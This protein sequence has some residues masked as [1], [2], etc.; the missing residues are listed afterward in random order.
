S[1]SIWRQKE[2]FNQELYDNIDN[3][4]EK[5]KGQ[6]KIK[7]RPGQDIMSYDI[8]DII[9]NKEIL[10]IEAGVG[11][12]KSWAY[13]ITLISASKN[14]EKFNGFIISTSSIALEE[15]LE[16]E[17]K[18]VSELLGIDINV[19]VAKGKNNYLCQKRL[20]N[21]LKFKDSKRKYQ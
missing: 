5:L 8:F 13:L 20:D 15:Q 7:D 9:E 2:E 14:K 19:T 6:K 12:G 11:I 10:V 18:K 16:Q 4:F 21:F 17:V 1:M 3:F